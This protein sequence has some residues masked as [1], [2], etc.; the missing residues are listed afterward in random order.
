VEHDGELLMDGGI[1]NN[2]PIEILKTKD[3]DL[4]IGV[5]VQ[6][7]LLTKE[8]IK[9]VSEILTQISNFRSVE[10]MQKKIQLTD[11]YIE[12]DVDDY[13]IISF[14]KG[15]EIIQIGERSVAPFLDNLSA[16]ASKQNFRKPYYHPPVL[17]SL[18]NK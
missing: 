17:D 13:S 16:I 14:N 12:P 2:Y 5:N 9:S 3:V 18:E 7:D 15:A 6:D 11:I 1:A 8:E 10:S 4:I